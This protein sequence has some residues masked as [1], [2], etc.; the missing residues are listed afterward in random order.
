MCGVHLVRKVPAHSL[1]WLITYIQKSK[2]VWISSEARG[3]CEE[4]IVSTVNWSPLPSHLSSSPSSSSSSSSFSSSVFSQATKVG[5][6][7][8]RWSLLASCPTGP[9]T[10]SSSSATRWARPFSGSIQDQVQWKSRWTSAARPPSSCWWR[11]WRGKT[12]LICILFFYSPCSE[13]IFKL[14]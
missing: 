13:L 8:C 14:D 12:G 2:L 7:M 4:S 3:P 1:L 9:T 6:Q 5:R 11:S 10:P